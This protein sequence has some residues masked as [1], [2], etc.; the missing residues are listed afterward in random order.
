MSVPPNNATIKIYIVCPQSTD[1]LLCCYDKLIGQVYYLTDGK[2]TEIIH[3][4]NG[5]I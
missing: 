5:K 2:K 4:P 1:K 3:Q